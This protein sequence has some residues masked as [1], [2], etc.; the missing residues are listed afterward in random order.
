MV[1]VKGIAEA[2]QLSLAGDGSLRVDPNFVPSRYFS[3][4]PEALS[5]E[6]DFMRVRSQACL[7]AGVGGFN[8]SPAGDAPQER[9]IR[10]ACY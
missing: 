9:I 6:S 2:T 4:S 10:L 3:R 7:D 8:L 5:A 1:D